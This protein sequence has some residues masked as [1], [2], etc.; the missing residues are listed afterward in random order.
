MREEYATFNN[1]PKLCQETNTNYTGYGDMYLIGNLEVGGPEDVTETETPSGST[2]N[3]GVD[4]ALSCITSGGQETEG[5]YD[6]GGD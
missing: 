3:M 2:R 1:P 5:E 4:K 6:V